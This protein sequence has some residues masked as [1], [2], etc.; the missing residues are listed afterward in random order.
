MKYFIA[1]ILFALVG[2]PTIDACTDW[3][4]NQSELKSYKIAKQIH[5]IQKTINSQDDKQIVQK[6]KY[7]MGFT[8][9]VGFEVNNEQQ[10]EYDDE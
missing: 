7:P 6:P 3:I 5:D 8:S 2:L 9:C 4:S 1:G 10:E